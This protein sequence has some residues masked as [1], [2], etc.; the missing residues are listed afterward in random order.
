MKQ[1]RWITHEDNHIDEETLING[2][3][4]VTRC[5]CELLTR[6][7]TM[8]NTETVFQ[9]HDYRGDILDTAAIAAVNEHPFY[10]QANLDDINEQFRLLE[11]IVLDA[12]ETWFMLENENLAGRKARIDAECE[13]YEGRFLNRTISTVDVTSNFNGWAAT[14]SK[15][16]AERHL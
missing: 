13:D 1:I 9:M 11:T 2:V 4:A 14:A 8:N 7:M 15:T 12:Q 10:L 3:W 6:R 5:D 16:W